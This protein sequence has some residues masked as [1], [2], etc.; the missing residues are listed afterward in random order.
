MSLA[1]DL[2]VASPLAGA[3][4]RLQD[5][6]MRGALAHGLPQSVCDARP[7]STE[8]EWIINSPL[9]FVN[10]NETEFRPLAKW[11]RCLDC[12]QAGKQCLQQAPAQQGLE[13]LG[14]CGADLTPAGP[15][16]PVILFL[17]P[18]VLVCKLQE[19]TKAQRG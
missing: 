11:D 14:V 8:D 18:H 3:S 6:S 9:P 10:T 16:A 17:K 5:P 1:L 4:R 7:S 13:G 2:V 15:A 12:I 19:E